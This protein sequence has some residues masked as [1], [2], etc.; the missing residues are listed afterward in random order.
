MEPRGSTRIAVIP[1]GQWLSRVRRRRGDPVIRC[2]ASSVLGY[3]MR[4]RELLA[5]VGGAVALPRLAAREAMPVIGYPSLR[6]I[7]RHRDPAVFSV[8]SQNQ[9]SED[10]S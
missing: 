9:G 1:R 8:E 6:R 2:A 4:R 7:Y 3:R 5:L 10:C